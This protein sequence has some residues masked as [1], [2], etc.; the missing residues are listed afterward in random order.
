MCCWFASHPLTTTA[1]HS[2]PHPHRPHQGL[3]AQDILR[4]L[5]AEEAAAPDAPAAITS[6]IRAAAAAGAAAAAV[7]GSVEAGGRIVDLLQL[8]SGRLVLQRQPPGAGAAPAAQRATAR[9]RRSGAAGAAGAAA[10]TASG[11]LG[12]CLEMVEE[13][14]HHGQGA[15]AGVGGG[16]DRPIA[17]AAAGG[18]AAAAAPPRQ[19]KRPSKRRAPMSDLPPAQRQELAGQ[20]H[21]PVTPGGPV[22]GAAPPEA[23]QPGNGGATTSAAAP[24]F[25][26]DVYLAAEK[27]GEGE[28]E[29]AAEGAQAAAHQSA[30]AA[31]AAGDSAMA[32]TADAAAHAAAQEHASSHFVGPDSGTKERRWQWDAARGV[33]VI[34]VRV[35]GGSVGWLINCVK[36]VTRAGSVEPVVT[37]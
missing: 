32:G 33:P 10:T 12:A 22:G 16:T 13:F 18:A 28:E 21:A 30:A 35:S 1:T 4:Q 3:S 27:E 34:E 7:C 36:G 14:L 23:Q 26:Y 24:G 37:A 29:E 11:A 6:P 17:G 15:A 2:T 8:A 31:D 19:L 5:A 20:A 9:E 25:V